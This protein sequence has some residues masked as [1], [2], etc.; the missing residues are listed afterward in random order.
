MAAKDAR[1]RRD[2]G[3]H[4]NNREKMVFWQVYLVINYKCMYLPEL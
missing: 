2:W 4:E 3:W 1:P